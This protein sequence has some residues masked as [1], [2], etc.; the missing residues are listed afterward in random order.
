MD[1]NIKTFQKTTKNSKPKI[2]KYLNIFI[3][4]FYNFTNSQPN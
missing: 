1:K 4:Y 2:V 3:E